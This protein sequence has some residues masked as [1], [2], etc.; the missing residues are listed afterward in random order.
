MSTIDRTK[1]LAALLACRPA[2][3]SQQFVPAYTHFLF[4]RDRVT[5]YNDKLGIQVVLE[6]HDIDGCLPGD[7]LIKS[8]QTMTGDKVLVQD[9]E[10]ERAVQLACGRAKVTL[11]LLMAED[12][13][14][15]WPNTEKQPFFAVTADVLAGLDACLPSVGINANQPA[16]QGVT[17]TQGSGGPVLWSTDGNT[18]TQF[19]CNPDKNFELPGEVPLIMPT[20]FCEQVLAMSKTYGKADQD[21]IALPGM[22][23][24]ECFEGAEA[25]FVARVMCRT[26]VDLV[27]LDFEGVMRRHAT[28]EEWNELP[29]G[30]EEALQRALVV[31]A[32]EVDKV[33]RFSKHR[34]A[35]KVET[36]SAITEGED[37]LDYG[38]NVPDKTALDPVLVLRGSKRATE[39]IFGAKALLLRGEKGKFTHM[40]AYYAG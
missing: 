33:A 12:F 34:G 4:T 38:G 31:T 29:P 36:K 11:P 27:P 14:I 30:W 19:M 24:C 13:P 25:S 35:L 8:L 3:A 37:M 16:Q 5:A 17:I 15:K 39:V 9:V 32:S 28:Q 2:L 26:L 23:V 20:Q 10:G 21:V 18:I 40:V 22:V 7:M 1:F 6:G